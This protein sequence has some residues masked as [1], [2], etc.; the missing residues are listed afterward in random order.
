[1]KKAPTPAN[2]AERM[3]ALERFAILDTGPDTVLDSITQAAADL[4]E[5]PVALISL[6]DS[7]RQWFKSSIGMPVREDRP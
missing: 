1:M 6:V 7:N 2:E 5:T 4:C 3:A